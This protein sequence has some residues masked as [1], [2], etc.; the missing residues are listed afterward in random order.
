MGVLADFGGDS[1][2][3][4][5]DCGYVVEVIDVNDGWDRSAS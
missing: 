3:E 2:A 5:G 4:L 1:G